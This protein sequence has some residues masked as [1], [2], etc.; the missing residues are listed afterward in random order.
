MINKDIQNLQ[1][2]TAVEIIPPASLYLAI[3]VVKHQIKWHEPHLT[4]F[5]VMHH[6]N[7]K[8]FL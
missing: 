3:R 5:I 4:S 6:I 1:F 8:K 2:Y 7:E